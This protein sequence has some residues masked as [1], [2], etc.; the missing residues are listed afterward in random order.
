MR[1]A[2]RSGCV[3][4]IT[5]LALLA[6]APAAGAAH[7]S[8][9]DRLEADTKLDADL[10][11]CSGNAVVIG[12]SGVTLDLAGHTIE[13]AHGGIGVVNAPGVSRVTIEN[14]NIGGFFHAV[15]LIEGGGH[16]L[17][18]VREYD[19]HDGLRLSRVNGALLDR[20]IATGNDGSGVHTPGSSGVTIRHSRIDHNAAGFTA[21]GLQASTIERSVIAWN[22]FYGIFCSPVTGSVFE[23]NV[24]YGNGEFGIRLERGSSG[25]RIARNRVSKTT[26]HGIFMAAAAS[27]N[28]LFGNRVT[29]NT[30]DGISVL[31]PDSTLDGNYAVRNGALGINAPAGAAFAHDNVARRN[32]DPRECVG[33][34]CRR[35]HGAP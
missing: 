35:P 25:N 27:A 30:G 26:G 2:G 11:G 10:V 31:G 33:V 15:V 9:G 24:V 18:N 28:L 34:P 17:R 6:S 14:G 12:A 22:T 16:V 13:G 20:V 23:R 21:A 32:G 8:C 3:A 19:S 4:A 7:V 29:R 1:R 5:L